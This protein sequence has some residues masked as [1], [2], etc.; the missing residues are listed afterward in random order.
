MDQIRETIAA[1]GAT[2]GKDI[3][4]TLTSLYEP[5]Q[6]VANTKYADTI[7]T[8]K[9]KKYGP[10]PRHRLDVYYPAENPSSPLPV[11]VY[12][13]GGAYVAGDTETSPNIYANIGNYFASRGYVAVLATYRLVFQGAKFPS[14]A[15]D[16]RDALRWVRDHVGGYSG[17]GAR[18]VVLGQSAGGGHLATALFTGLL[19]GTDG[20]PLVRGVVLLSAALG[21]D[22][23]R[24]TQMFDIMKEYYGTDSRFEMAARWSPAA[25]FRQEFFGTRDRAPR[26]GMPCEVLVLWAEWEIEEIMGGNMEWFADYRRRFGRLPL[27]EVM[28]GQNH[29]SYCMGLGLEGEEYERVGRR[30]VEFV[31]EVTS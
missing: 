25:L 26:D 6:A 16:V 1:Y 17:D 8:D 10:D 13:H 12:V 18:V 21:N 5:L 30:L 27:V 19:D 23:D 9:A 20:I 14:G 28:K 31:K 22:H 15:E 2:W 4:P 11:V 7:K 24:R 29:V 3:V